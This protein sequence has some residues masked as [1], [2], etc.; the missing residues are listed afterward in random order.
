MADGDLIN[1]NDI[2]CCPEITREPCC[3]RLQVTYTLQNRVRDDVT[4]EVSIVAELERCPGPLA[5]GD[6]VYST[7]LLP[8]ERVRLNTSSRNTRFTY[9]A[10]S[11]VSYRHEQ[12]SEE[13]Y[14]MSSMDRFMSDLSV[15]DS[16]SGGQQSESDFEVNTSGSYASI[17]F[18]GGGKVNVEGDFSAESSFDFLRE[19]S[20][21]AESSHERSVQATR[22]VNAVQVG[23]VQSRSHAEGESESAYEAST[24]V[25]ENRNQCHAVTY[26]AYQLVKKQ[27]VRFR[28]KAVLR[29]VIDPAGNAVADARPIRPPTGVRVLPNGILATAATR[30]EVETAGRTGAAAQQANLIGGIA[31]IS[32]IV[33]L[34]SQPLFAAASRFV[35]V[36]TPRPV[37]RDTRAAALKAVDED[38]VRT[39]I[40]DKVGGGVSPKLQA[41]LGFERTTC[42]PTQAIMVKGCLDRCNVCEEPR[43]KAIELDLERKALE[44]RLLQRQIE[45]LDKAQEYRCCPA[46][47]TEEPVEA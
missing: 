34:R 3:E 19:V 1:I 32:D 6:V 21:H 8:G 16:A 35:P 30:V 4:V 36:A 22:A 40:L 33:G 17:G 44:N 47:G 46:D 37:P 45:L 38:L 43:Q 15:R 23:E 18:A 31:G 10:E 13:T 24:R 42:L 20:R 39:G 12:S 41:E 25:F 28:I 27:T 29:R 7:T 2:P 9:D 11:E 5:L 14:Y 26:F